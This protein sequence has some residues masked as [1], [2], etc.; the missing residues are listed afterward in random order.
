MGKIG[1]QLLGVVASIFKLSR[2]PVAKAIAQLSTQQLELATDPVNEI[3]GGIRA[4]IGGVDY[5]AG[6]VVF[7]Q[8]HSDIDR[9]DSSWFNLGTTDTV[10]LLSRNGLV[11]A[12]FELRDQIRPEARTIVSAL[13]SRGIAVSLISGDQR[14]AVEYVGQCLGIRDSKGELSPEEKLDFVQTMQSAGETIMMVGDGLNDAPSLALADF[15][16]AMGS[17]I[18]LTKINADVVLANNSLE[19]LLH[20][21]DLSHSTKKVIKQNYVWATTYNLLA[22]PAALFGL[23][24][25]WLAALGMSASSL[26][27][28]F[29][30]LRL[31]STQS[32]ISAVPQQKQNE[33]D[34]L[35][36]GD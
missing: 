26:F 6:S 7:V 30:S 2:H 28:V 25:P 8:K 10:C 4:T 16:I 14:S 24:P 11:V 36:E 19:A 5:V 31:L 33:V 34:P 13:R 15:S 20:I 29:N 35:S 17:G 18:D 23:V 27:V 9:N 1:A 3:G 32:K 12:R 21:L 22:I